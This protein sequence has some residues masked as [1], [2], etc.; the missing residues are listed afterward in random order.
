MIEILKALSSFKDDLKELK[1]A[2]SKL[3]RP[4]PHPLSGAW[5]DGQDVMMLL[6]IS[7]RNLQNLRD[8]EILPYSRINGKFYYKAADIQD[9]LEKNYSRNLTRDNVQTLKSE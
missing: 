3:T 1:T 6:H 7:K 4:A 9:L 8:R 2:V 5:L